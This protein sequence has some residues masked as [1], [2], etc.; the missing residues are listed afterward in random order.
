MVLARAVLVSLVNSGA[1]FGHL[2]N[3][4][5]FEPWERPGDVGRVLAEW[6]ELGRDPNMGDICWINRD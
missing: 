2:A 6:R 4:G 3:D 5:G 1:Q